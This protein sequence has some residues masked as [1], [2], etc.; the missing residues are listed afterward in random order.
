[1]AIIGPDVVKV[2]EQFTVALQVT[3]AVNLYGTPFTLVYDPNFLEFVGAS[4]GDL[5]RKDGKPTIFKATDD[6]VAGKVVVGLTRI[7]SV[8]GVNG[9]GILA[10]ATFKAKNKGPA[11]IGFTGVNFLGPAAKQLE[12]IP[13]N[14]VVDV[15]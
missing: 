1:M 9:S 13:Y 6:K 11:S 14:A 8:G 12:V 4:E 15:Q 7:G 2:T 3:D 10:Q 5:L